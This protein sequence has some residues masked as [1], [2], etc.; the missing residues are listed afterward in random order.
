MKRD[1]L[2]QSL[3]LT[4]AFFLLLITPALSQETLKI[5]EQRSDTSSGT[6]VS[7]EKVGS[8][9]NLP[10]TSAQNVVQAPVQAV[11]PVTAVKVN[12]TDKGVEIILETSQGDKLQVSPKNEGNTYI[13]D[14]PNA[15]LRLSNGETTFRQEKPTAGISLLQVTNQDPNTVRLTVTGESGLPTVEL[16]D[17]DEG[18]IFGFIPVASVTQQPSSPQPPSPE[19]QSPQPPASESTSTESTAE[20]DEPIEL[21]VTAT[22]T[23]EDVLNVPRSVTVIGREQIEEQAKLSTNL[24]DILAKTVP[25]FGSPTNRSNIFGQTLRGRNIS[26]L[27][28]GVPQNS[29]LQSIPAALSTIDPSAIERIEVVR[30]PNA[31]YG[32]QA[33]GGVI[34][35]ITKR[36]SGQ[37]LTS[38][39]DIGLNTSL[40]RSEDSFGYKLSHQISG[41]EGKFDY[42]LGFS[43]ATAAGF[44]DADGDRIANFS[45]EDDI[46]KLNVLSK[47]GVELSPEQRLQF[48]FNHYQQ[49]QDTEF[50]SDPEIDNIPGIQKSRAIRLPEGTTVIG[51]RNTDTLKNTLVNLNYTN[52]NIFGSKLSSQLY[53]RKNIFPG[54]F[55]NDDREGFTGFVFNTPGDSQQIG[56][57]LQIETP[58]TQAKTVSLLWGIDYTNEQSSQRFEIFDA[59][60]LDG[61][62]GRV[63]R[64]IEERTFVPNYDLNDLGLF[65][66]LQ[67]DINNSVQVSGGLRHVRI[68]FDV[69]DYS[70]FD[71]RNIQGGGRDFDDTVFNAGIVYKPTENISVFANF[72]QGFSVPDIGRVLR[73]PPDDFVNVSDS[74]RLTEPQKVNN[75]EIGIRGQWPNVQAS[76][77]A[78]Y[79]TSDLGL[80]F[81][82]IDDFLQTIRAPQRIYGIEAAVDVE[83]ATGWKLGG[84]ATWTEGENDED[85]DGNYLALNSITVPPLKLTA[86]VENETIKGWRNRLQLL[87][88]GDR[89]R[90]FEDEVDGGAISSYVTV[91]YLSSIKLGAGELQIGI[92]NL[93]NNQ[94]FPVYS[95]YFAPFFDSGNYAGQGTTLSIGYRITW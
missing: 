61:T 43:L 29:N 77:A 55:P 52:D 93:F 64:K 86:Y 21:V 88:S 68:G 35:I 9:I 59:N 8:Q 38:T 53:F 12:P 13:A 6:S 19:Q 32:G 80:N 49:E 34:N 11:I 82:V 76:V 51:A 87:Y 67:W 5:D 95:Q 36:P 84:T 39:T 22:R 72:A 94:Y 73:L 78:F 57:R 10:H 17:G 58:L 42:T 66:Q 65:T 62:G 92:Q 71:G 16:F 25:G 50:I 23:E 79:N 1:Q 27:I 90:A 63:Y 69:D 85:N 40:T 33:T 30:G 4:G 91:D 2:F 54:G 18:L 37:K 31:I 83:P 75:Y 45:G 74:V 14:I 48:T 7:S 46:T 3:L 44:Y 41:T 60:E 20:S 81:E 89:D 56:G 28:D 47:I 15:Q 24:T 26:V 70:T